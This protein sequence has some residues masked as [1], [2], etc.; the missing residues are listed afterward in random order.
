MGNYDLILF[1]MVIVN[2]RP[3]LDLTVGAVFA[4]ITEC[5]ILPLVDG[6]QAAGP[7]FA[8]TSALAETVTHNQ[9]GMQLLY[10][11]ALFESMAL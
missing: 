11:S 8:F 7:F 2:S 4:S 10:N 3:T 6:R 1:Y 5:P 9:H